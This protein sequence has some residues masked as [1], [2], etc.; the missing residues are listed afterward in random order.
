MKVAL[1]LA[2]LAVGGFWLFG[3]HSLIVDTAV[4]LIAAHLI[5]KHE[6]A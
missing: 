5:S 2:V 1:V 3:V 4:G 6:R